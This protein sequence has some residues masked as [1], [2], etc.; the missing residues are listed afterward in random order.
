VAVDTTGESAFYPSFMRELIQVPLV[1][2]LNVP[3]TLGVDVL[4]VS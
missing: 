4:A 3:A 2:E 1:V